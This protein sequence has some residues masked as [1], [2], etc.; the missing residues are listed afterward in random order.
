M[1]R[2]Q[3]SSVVLRPATSTLSASRASTARHRSRGQRAPR[4]SA[5]S[6]PRTRIPILLPNTGG[7]LL[8]KLTR[9]VSPSL[10]LS[11]TA[12]KRLPLHEAVLVALRVCA[13]RTNRTTKAPQVARRRRGEGKCRSRATAKSLGTTAHAVHFGTRTTANTTTQTVSS[14]MRMQQQRTTLEKTRVVP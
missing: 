11:T 10:Q 4:S 5:A 13:T 2:P 1:S 9:H 8:S 7:R 12:W 3:S 6:I 14:P